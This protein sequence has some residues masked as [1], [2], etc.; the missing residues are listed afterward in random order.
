MWT[1]GCEGRCGGHK[2]RN[3]W[4][5]HGHKWPGGA[6]NGVRGKV[7]DASGTDK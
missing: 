5:E 1:E 6:V 4:C 7:N 2:W 3:P